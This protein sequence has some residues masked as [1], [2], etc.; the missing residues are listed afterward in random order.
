MD[1]QLT[2]LCMLLTAGKEPAGMKHAG[3][4]MAMAMGLHGL[5]SHG[6]NPELGERAHSRDDSIRPRTPMTHWI[7]W[8]SHVDIATTVRWFGKSKVSKV[9]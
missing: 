4:D 2:D 7:R 6:S 5:M 9:I 1:S 3:K 8:H